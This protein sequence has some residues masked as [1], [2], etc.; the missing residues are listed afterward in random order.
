[1]SRP[2]RSV[3]GRDACALA[4]L[5]PVACA[6]L[7]AAT[8]AQQHP[9]VVAPAGIVA[10]ERP[11][12]PAGLAEYFLAQE[13]ERPHLR[14]YRVL[15]PLM[16][17]P[18]APSLDD[19]ERAAA[20]LVHQRLGVD[21]LLPT[22]ARALDALGA[23]NLPSEDLER[24]LARIGVPVDLVARTT[25][26]GVLAEIRAR[27]VAGEALEALC[28]ELAA[29]PLVYTPTI[30]GFVL[31]SESGEL[32]LE[33]VR[34]QLTRDTDFQAVG[35][36]GALDLVRSLAEAV[37]ELE[38]VVHAKDEHCAGL[39]REFAAWPAT[40][41]ERFVLFPQA[42]SVSQWAQDALEYGFAPDAH[43]PA[44]REG[45]LLAPRY[46]SRGE[47]FGT[48]APGDELASEIYAA[49]GARLARSPL[50]FQGGNILCAVDPKTGVRWLVMGEAELHR[51]VA[52]G[53]P[54]DAALAALRAEFG[55]QRALVLPAN[56]FHIDMELTLRAHEGRLM[57]IVA[58]TGAASRAVLRCALEGLLSAGVMTAA[59]VATA[60][61]HLDANRGADVAAL[62]NQA[63]GQAAVGPGRFPKRFA[64][65]FQRGEADSGVGNLQRVLLALDLLLAE[66]LSDP[67]ATG[68]N[69]ETALYLTSL[70]RREMQRLQV[71]QALAKEGFE[72][73]AVPSL[74][75]ARRSLSTVNGLHGPGVY[76]MPVNGGFLAGFDQSAQRAFEAVLPGVRVVPV[77]SGE[78]LRRAGSLHCA[79]FSMPKP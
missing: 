29:R 25:Q 60:R 65:H 28:T 6:T 37:P 16:G 79:A 1:V 22:V 21:G 49:A 12:L 39:Q 76:L 53:L 42:R 57:A 35:D 63:L 64:D 40:R 7:A 33:R 44:G 8:R 70:R 47:E 34:V 24:R 67:Q 71:S 31:S 54:R 58:D 41:R 72:V 38:F 10:V 52:L 46:A 45:W 48:L 36:G 5:V 50:I 77:R 26:P 17:D 11:A 78:T 69:P 74:S 51:N 30:P 9:G 43:D 62:F 59:D 4:V 23:R 75:D 66:L 55:C 56:S 3:R 27:L 14:N 2:A 19:V 13:E 18:R 20:R 68:I 15:D 61:D 73:A 32:P